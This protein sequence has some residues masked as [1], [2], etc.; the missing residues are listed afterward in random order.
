[1]ENFQGFEIIIS[2]SSCHLSNI[3]NRSTG[4]SPKSEP[5]KYGQ[6][7]MVSIFGGPW[8]CLF[9]SKLLGRWWEPT[10]WVV[11]TLTSG[12]VTWTLSAISES[13]Y[14]LFCTEGEEGASTLLLM[15]APGPPHCLCPNEPPVNLS[16]PRFFKLF[17]ICQI[18]QVQRFL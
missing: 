4:G 12:G 9:T 2:S 1:M 11:G 5:R 10:N 15:L 3:K 6:N 13:F 8:L 17:W 16:I 14:L 7:N 18:S